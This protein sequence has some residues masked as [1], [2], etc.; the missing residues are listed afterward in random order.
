[1]IINAGDSH[2]RGLDSDGVVQIFEQGRPTGRYKP[3]HSV[4]HQCCALLP[5]P[6]GSVHMK[7]FKTEFNEFIKAKCQDIWL[8][9]PV[10]SSPCPDLATISFP[11]YNRHKLYSNAVIPGGFCRGL[12]MKAA[13]Q[14]Y[15]RAT[16]SSLILGS[17]DWRWLFELTPEEAIRKFFDILEHLYDR[18]NFEVLFISTMFPR[19]EMYTWEG[20]LISGEQGG[21]Y[22]NYKMGVKEFNQALVLARGKIDIRIKNVQGENVFLKWRVVDMTNI[23]EYGKM[24]DTK[25]Y[26]SRSGDGT[27]IKGIYSERFLEQLLN[28]VKK[29]KHP[30][31]RT[32]VR[33][34]R[35]PKQ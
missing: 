29:Y 3:Y 15:R 4:Y 8:Q 34:E 14:R 11:G 25:M 5:Q 21:V 28:E 24:F 32:Q 2:Q 9:S 23:L 6:S 26:C 7:H 1:M 19:R 33:K 17:N 22:E 31:K 12:T 20:E 16:M 27:H 35:K 30:K 10:P 13:L 18:T